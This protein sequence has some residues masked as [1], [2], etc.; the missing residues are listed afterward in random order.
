MTGRLDN[1][2][3]LVVGAGSIGHDISNGAADK[4]QVALVSCKIDAFC[5][6]PSVREGSR[7]Q[8]ELLG[9]THRAALQERRARET[10][11]SVLRA[12]AYTLV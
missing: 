8:P 11:E 4:Q 5:V 9:D 1:K 3:V 2:V 10:D 12:L 6:K 7:N